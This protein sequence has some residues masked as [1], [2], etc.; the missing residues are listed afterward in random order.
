MRTFVTGAGVGRGRVRARRVRAERARPRTWSTGSGS[1]TTP[2]PGRSGRSSIAITPAPGACSPCSCASGCLQWRRAVA[3]PSRGWSWRA[4]LAHALDGRSLM[5]GLATLLLTVSVAAGASRSAMLALAA[6]RLCC[7][8]IAAPGQAQRGRSSLWTAAIA[9]GAHARGHRLCRSRS[10][11]VARR[12]D[13]QPRPGTTRRHLARYTRHRPRL[14][15]RR[16]RGGKL[17]QRDAR[18]SD[19]RPHL[20]LER[21]PQ[22][23]PA[24]RRRGRAALRHP[25]GRRARSRCAAAGW[26]ACTDAGD[27]LR[28]MRV[29]AA[30]SLVAV[31]IQSI[32]ETGAHPSRQRHARGGRGGHPRPPFPSR[33]RML[34]LGIDVDGVVADFRSAF[35]ALAERELRHCRRRTSRPI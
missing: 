4:R 14:P 25:G 20:F 27:H 10:P 34:R 12:R 22:P 24:D 13:A 9:I 26:R 7:V 17:R 16:G 18:V 11:D 8:A 15:R 33:T 23:V 5:L 21:S 6:A 32:W 35:R 3:S 28:W 19:G 2:A 1:R 29:G 31:A 30:A